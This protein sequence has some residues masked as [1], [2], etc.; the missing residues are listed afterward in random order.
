MWL[1]CRRIMFVDQINLD[2]GYWALSCQQDNAHARRTSSR[3]SRR[4]R[5]R[6]RRARPPLTRR[7]GG[8]MSSTKSSVN[9]ASW[10]MP[11]ARRCAKKKPFRYSNRSVPGQPISSCRRSPQGN[12]AKRSRI[13]SSNGPSSS[14]TLRTAESPSTP[15]S[16]RMRSAPLPLGAATG[17]SPIR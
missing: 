12:S 17:C 14:A 7:Y 5:R 4:C 11:N 16:P 13:C 15:I 9:Q 8:S 2:S 10:V 3:R 1:H 6:S